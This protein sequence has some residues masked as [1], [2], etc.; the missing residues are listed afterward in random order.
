MSRLVRA[1]LLGATVASGATALLGLSWLAGLRPT[2]YAVPG[3]AL[4]A[5]LAGADAATVV[6]VLAGL[7]GVAAGIAALAGALG[8]RGRT[9]TAALQVAVLGFVLQ[10]TGPLSTVGY[11]VAMAMPAAV[12]VLL[13]QVVRRYR[14]ARW[15]VGVP[16]LALLL[17]GG[18]LLRDAV[19]GVVRM[20]GAGLAEHGAGLILS[21]LLLVT[22][23]LWAAVGAQALSGTAAAERATAWVLRHRTAIT[24]VAATGPLPYALVRLTWLTPWPQLGFDIDLSARVWGLT[25]SSGAWLGVVLTLGLIRPWGEVFPRW[26]PGLAGRRVPVAAAAVPGGLVAATLIFSTVPMLVMFSDQTLGQ[27]VLGAIVFPCWYWGPA[28][29]LAVWGYVAHRTPVDRAR[30][31]RAEPAEQAARVPGLASPVAD[32]RG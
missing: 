7:T 4:L 27:A 28:L 20:L 21:L 8:T 2:T 24:I 23:A 10:G 29:A 30:E 26:M 11:L 25:L 1:T 12:V 31:N 5:Q 32:R 16:G 18:F 15:T 13:V 14:V 17:G 22:G 3:A 19:A 6:H 9:V